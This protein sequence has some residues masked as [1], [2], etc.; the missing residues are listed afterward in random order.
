LLVVTPSN[1]VPDLFRVEPGN[2][3][4]SYIVR[5]LEGDPSIVGTRMPPPPRAPLDQEE[6]DVIRQWIID[7]ALDN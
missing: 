1:E 3:D 6:I 2:P 7:G 4:D 5:K